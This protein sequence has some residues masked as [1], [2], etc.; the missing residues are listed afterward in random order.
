M[1]LSRRLLALALNVGLLI[2]GFA[3]FRHPHAAAYG[4][5]DAYV[6]GRGG[7]PAEVRAQVGHV[8]AAFSDGYRTRDLGAVGTFSTRLLSDDVMALGTMPKEVYVGRK[9]VTDL[10][11]TDWE[12]WG[13]CTFYPE[14]ARISSQG[15]TAWFAMI[16]SVVFDLSK[17]LVLPLRVSGVL[18]RDDGGWRFSQLQF[19]FDLDLTL[20]LVVDMVLLVW[21]AV[22]VGLLL[23]ILTRRLRGVS[24]PAR[25]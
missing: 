2:L 17:Y 13:N 3:I 5:P 8:L 21:L 14:T 6:Y 9:A 24:T 25:V 12:S 18:T 10:V 4:T 23:W 19:Q 1:S 22:N 7:A 16:G 11:R 20:L 15:D